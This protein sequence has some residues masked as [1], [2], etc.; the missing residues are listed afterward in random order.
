M[1]L[2]R[3]GS[4]VNGWKHAARVGKRPIAVVLA[5][6]AC[7]MYGNCLFLVQLYRR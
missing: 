5:L 3:C 7:R 6:F 2:R 1:A 4:E